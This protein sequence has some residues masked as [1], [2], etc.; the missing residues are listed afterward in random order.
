MARVFKQSPSTVHRGLVFGVVRP[1]GA[2]GC[3]GA[4]AVCGEEPEQRANAQV[5]RRRGAQG[6]VARRRLAASEQVQPSS[7]GGRHPQGAS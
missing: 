1:A 5:G 7:D 4:P 6:P 2:A 3:A